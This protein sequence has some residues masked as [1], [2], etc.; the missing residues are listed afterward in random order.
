MYNIAYSLK[1]E[2]FHDANFLTGCIGGCN[3]WPNSQIPECTHSISHNAQF[4]TEMCTFLFWMEHCGIWN[5]CIPGF[6]ILVY[7]LYPS[8]DKVGFMTTLGFQY[9]ITYKKSR[10]CVQ[11]NRNVII[12]MKFSSLAAAMQVQL[13]TKISSNLMTFQFQ[14]K[15][16]SK[17]VKTLLFGKALVKA[18]YLWQK[19]YFA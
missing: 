13:V 11:C 12:L 5:R 8:D 3:N 4:R 7:F 6:V 15:Y 16:W 18:K 10:K 2:C 19:P 17:D 1:P 9:F 14:C